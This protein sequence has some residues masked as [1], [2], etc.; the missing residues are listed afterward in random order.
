MNQ[1]IPFIQRDLLLKKVK[2]NLRYLGLNLTVKFG[3]PEKATKFEKIFVILMTRASC[4]LRA[5]AY[6]SK[7]RRRFFKT[8][9]VK[10]YFTEFN[11]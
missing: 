11:R 5:T 4:S 3:Y 1:F 10:L 7:S 9:V 6:L 8:N 2:V